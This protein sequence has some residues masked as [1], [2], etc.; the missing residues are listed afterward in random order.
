M[1]EFV[2]DFRILSPFLLPPAL[3]PPAPLIQ[4][5]RLAS[6]PLHHIVF[7]RALRTNFITM[8]LTV[9]MTLLPRS[10][11]HLHTALGIFCMGFDLSVHTGPFLSRLYCRVAWTTSRIRPVV[12]AWPQQGRLQKGRPWRLSSKTLHQGLSVDGCSR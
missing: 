12:H 5:H 4:R 7:S 3:P 10:P 9:T 1:Y 8:P 11:S 2:D 6:F